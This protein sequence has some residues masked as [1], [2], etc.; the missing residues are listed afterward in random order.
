MEFMQEHG[1]YILAVLGIAV[2]VVFSG[3]GSSI[4]VGEAGSAAAALTKDQ[5]EKFVQSLILQLLPGTQGLY[6]FAIGFLIFLQLDPAM[7]LALGLKLLIAAL[8]VGFVGWMS[9][10]YQ[11]KVSAAGMQILAKRPEKVINAIIYAVMV[12]TYAILA[13][14]F[15]FLLVQ[16]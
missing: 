5:P 4:G 8:P 7:D 10:K 9:G 1:G 11:G 16:G 14:V 3:F 2:A 12:E 15:S 13:F 6:G